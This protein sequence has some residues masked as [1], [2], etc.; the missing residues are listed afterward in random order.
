MIEIEKAKQLTEFINKSNY[1][2]RVLESNDLL[3]KLLFKS[4]K[5]PYTNLS[6]DDN[7]KINELSCF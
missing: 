7:K 3:Y 2:S 6:D 1:N 5:V 4:E